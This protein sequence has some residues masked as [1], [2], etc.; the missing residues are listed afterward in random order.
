[1]PHMIA[2]IL[3]LILLALEEV[4]FQ[5]LIRRGVIRKALLAPEDR[6]DAE[7][8]GLRMLERLRMVQLAGLA[9]LLVQL[10]TTTHRLLPNVSGQMAMTAMALQLFRMLGR[11]VLRHWSVLGEMQVFQSVFI[12]LSLLRSPAGSGVPGSNWFTA[13]S[14]GL[15]FLR[16]LNATALAFSVTYAARALFRENSSMFKSNPPMAFSDYWAGRVC[17]ACIPFALIAVGAMF[18]GGI[19][20]LSFRL[21]LIVSV[22]LVIATCVVFG[23]KKPHHPAAHV[24][25]ALSTLALLYSTLSGFPG[26]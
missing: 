8:S 16:A 14:L 12:I 17:T 24:L 20:D 22:L 6:S 21:H 4:L 5:S 1:M 2:G 11:Q 10:D 13:F 18:A 15:V 19:G 23:V 3:V 7:I 9:L 26:V 25:I